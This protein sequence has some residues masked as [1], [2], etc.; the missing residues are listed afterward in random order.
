M[1]DYSGLPGRAGLPWTGWTPWTTLDA[2]DALDWLDALDYPGRAGL[3]WT[4]WT[5]LD[6]LAVPRL[7]TSTRPTALTCVN[8]RAH[9]PKVSVAWGEAP[10]DRA[11]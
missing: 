8:P 2:L 9:W 6:V 7:K 5:T 4:L 1:L 11:S 3:L 10:I